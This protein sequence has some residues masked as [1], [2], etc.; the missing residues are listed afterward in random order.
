MASVLRFLHPHDPIPTVIIEDSPNICTL[1]SNHLERHFPGRFVIVGQSDDVDKGAALIREL[2][3]ELVLLDIDILGG[4]AFDLLD[5]LSDLRGTF[6]VSFITTF[7]KY[8][9]KGMEYGGVSF[10]DKPIS[11]SEFI[12]GITLAVNHVL[13]R[14]ALKQRWTEEVKAQLR[15]EQRAAAYDETITDSI[16]RDKN[17]DKTTDDTSVS[18]KAGS[19]AIRKR[20]AV[21]EFVAIDDIIYCLAEGSYT[22]LCCLNGTY[23]DSKTLKRYEELLTEWGFVRISRR[24]LINPR[25]CTL[26]RVSTNHFLITLP[27]GTELYAEGKHKDL[28]D[29]PWQSVRN[30]PNA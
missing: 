14:Q 27:D 10:I 18:I 17:T 16:F 2:R 29:A 19:I 21:T 20:D 26:A 22:A 8:I 23:T 4:T 9:R 5:L 25:H 15:A 6:T 28:P 3:P 30:I 11:V 24:M 7:D 13:D 1:I 12:R